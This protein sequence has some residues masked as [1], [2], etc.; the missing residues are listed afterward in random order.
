MMNPQPNKSMR[1][2]DSGARQ[3]SLS[4]DLDNHWSYLKTYGDEAWKAYPSY[5]DRVVPR[6]LEFLRE[7]NLTITFF[8]VTQDLRRDA[9][10]DAVRSIARHG[11]E[12][13]NHTVNHDPWLHQYSDQALDE[14]LGCAEEDI[15]RITGSRTVGF[16]G[17]GFSF[18]ESVLRILVRRGYEYDASVFPNLLNPLGRL[19]F[20]ARSGLSKAER[21][22]RQ[23]LF[24]TL[25]DALRPVKPFTWSV[26]GTHLLE[27]PVTTMPLLRLPFH[28]SYLIYLSGFSLAVMRAYWRV[29]LLLCRMTNTEPSMLLH[30]LD[31]LGR[32]DKVGL[33]F[34]PGMSLGVDHKL[35]VVNEILKSLSDQYS[36]VNMR[37]HARMIRQRAPSDLRVV[38]AEA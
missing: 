9:D 24:G 30:P 25:A 20:F 38:D 31:F 18:S 3:A 4:L 8:V 19:Y 29:A 23:A 14:E 34:F 2:D 32:E 17:P 15:Q 13:G 35:A 10:A 22:Q 33:E 1:L 12:I 11:H 37:E 28:M 26:A 5:L 27:I 21:K 36:I 7:R 6:C 16:R